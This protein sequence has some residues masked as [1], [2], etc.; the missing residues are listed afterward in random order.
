MKQYQSGLNGKR[1]QSWRRTLSWCLLPALIAMVGAG[2]TS[3]RKVTADMNPAGDYT[4][5]TVD[6]KQVPCTVRHE[7]RSI[8]IDSGSFLVNA[9]GTCS[10]KMVLAG[11]ATAIE[12]KATYTREGSKMSM[13][14]RGAGKTTGTIESDTFTMTN[15]GIVFVYRK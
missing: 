12:A 13:Q 2:C 5:A 6:G 7:G 10:S 9:D 14:W 15:E 1:G 8:A 3:E 11:R 4:L